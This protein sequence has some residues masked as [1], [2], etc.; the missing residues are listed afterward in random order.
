M[1]GTTL[2][3]YRI[4][5][6]LSEGGMGR[7]FLAEDPTLTRRVAIKLLPPAF[8]ARCAEYAREFAW[9]IEARPGA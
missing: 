3:R 8:A 2:G 7:V 9:P 6:P 5:Q 4:L 1:I